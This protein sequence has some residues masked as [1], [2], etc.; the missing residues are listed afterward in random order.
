MIHHLAIEDFLLQSKEY[1]TL[2]VRS[3]GEYN[4]AHIPHAT[5]LPL[6]NT[7]ERKL[8]GTA[9]KQQ[10]RN[11]AILLG[12]DIV[13]KKMGDFI[14][15]VQPHIRNN[16]VFVHCWRGGMRSGSMAWLL[17]L[18]GYDVYVLKGGYKSYRQ[19]I[20]SVLAQKFPYIVLGGRTGSG[21]TEVLLQLK[22]LGEQ[23][24]DLEG[25]ANHKGSA[26]GSLGQ[27]VQPSTEH[28]ENLLGEELKTFNSSKR[29]WLEDESRTIGNVF[30]DLSF[31]NHLRLSRLIVI[32]LPLDIR[33]KRLVAGYSENHTDGLVESITKIKKRL[34]NEQWKNAIDALHEKNFTRVAEI[35][36][37]YYDKA[38]D[39]GIVMKET[40]EI[41]RIS[42][43]ADDLNAIATTLL[44]T[45]NMKYGN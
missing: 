11:E 26:F 41:L 20:L 40:K 4:Y 43:E 1:L 15:F 21:K 28:F 29:V 34:G 24:I 7:E 16:K 38:Y 30:L 45:A 27:P 35:A 44:E 8:V 12:L 22:K 14:R 36:L 23:V 32:D 19:H 31:W 25:L 6:F 42:F 5:N 17:N 10:S 9:Y 18:F 2:D 3:D 33:V 37:H 13:G 39:K